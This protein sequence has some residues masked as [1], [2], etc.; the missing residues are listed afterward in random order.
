MRGVGAPGVFSVLP[1][2]AHEWRGDDLYVYSFDSGVS[3]LRRPGPGI[4]SRKDPPETSS[5]VF[6]VSP[7]D[8]GGLSGAHR[9]WDWTVPGFLRHRLSSQGGSFPRVSGGRSPS[10][11]MPPRDPTARGSLIVTAGSDPPPPLGTSRPGSGPREASRSRDPPKMG[12]G[13]RSRS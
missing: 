10:V 6:S 1:H 11:S 3:A 4:G 9:C 12:S 8:R 7:T 2:T 13:V 5:S